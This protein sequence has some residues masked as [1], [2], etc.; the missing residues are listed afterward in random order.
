MWISRKFAPKPIA[1][2]TEQGTVIANHHG[3]LEA[4]ATVPSKDIGQ[5]APYGYQ[6]SVP[7]GEEILI[8]HSDNGQAALGTKISSPAPLENGE[9]RISSKGGANIVLR[10][11]GSVIINSL[12]IDKNGVIKN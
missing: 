10:N 7:I 4:G 6:A 8:L 1:R 3:S 9:I 5:Y 12:V 2:Q 11:D